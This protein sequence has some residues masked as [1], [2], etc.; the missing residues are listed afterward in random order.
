MISDSPL[1]QS[2]IR[3]NKPGRPPVVCRR[4]SVHVVSAAD[5]E[6]TLDD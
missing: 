3:T 1:P 2:G 4:S 6:T 5:E